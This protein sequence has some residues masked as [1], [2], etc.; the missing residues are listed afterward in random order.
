[1][2]HQILEQYHMNTRFTFFILLLLLFSIEGIHAQTGLFGGLAFPLKPQSPLFGKDIVIHDSSSQNQRQVA[3]CSAFNGWLYA[4]YTYFSTWYNCPAFTVLKSVDNGITWTVIIDAPSDPVDSNFLSLDMVIIG[5]SISNLKLFVAWVITSNSPGYP[6]QGY[7]DRFDG[8]T[9]DWEDI[10][11][12]AYACYSI[13]LCTDFMYPASNSNPH[14]LGILYSAE[15]IGS[16]RQDSIIFC[17]SSDGGMTLNNR[18][19]IA[20]TTVNKFHNVALA[21]GRSPSWSSGRYFATWEEKNNFTSNTGHIFTAHSNPD[22][23]SAFSKPACIDSLDP[24]AINKVRNPVIACQFSGSDNDSSNLTEVIMLEKQLSSNSYDTR[25]F[26]NLQATTSSHFNE[27]SLTSSSNNKTESDINFNPFNS[28]F[29]LTYYDSTIKS[30]PFLTNNVNLSNPSTWNII[31][32]AYNDSPDLAAPYPKVALDMGQQQGADVWIK[33]GTGG[34]GVAMFDAQ[35]STYTGISDNNSG[36]LARLIGIYPNPS[37]DKITVELTGATLDGNLTIVNI[38]GQ[39]LITRQITMTK[40]QIDISNLPSGI[41]FVRLTND[42]T[43]EVGKI[44]KE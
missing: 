15:K 26:Y 1:M 23:N 4:G 9:G 34:N 33:E 25:G 30:L 3:I 38:E 12:E 5:D 44:I 6:G 10:L 22:F 39:Q 19:V 11:I 41:Y 16:Q 7:V 32:P 37:T 29:M 43:V 17:S 24:S 35:Y 14:S 8:I 18:Q 40:T 42:K 21:Y 36:S 2:R 31:S 20:T 27:F 28:I 13:A